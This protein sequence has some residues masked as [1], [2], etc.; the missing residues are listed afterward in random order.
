MNPFTPALV[1]LASA[2]VF[3]T[4]MKLLIPALILGLIAAVALLVFRKK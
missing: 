4:P 1:F 3:Y 2:G